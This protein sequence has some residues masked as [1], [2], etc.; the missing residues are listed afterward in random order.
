MMQRPMAKKIARFAVFTHLMALLKFLS[1]ETNHYK[2]KIRLGR[3]QLKVDGYPLRAQ[4]TFDASI[5]CHLSS[6]LITNAFVVVVV[7]V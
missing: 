7:V 4:S 1:I 2:Y 3:P 5:I 6:S